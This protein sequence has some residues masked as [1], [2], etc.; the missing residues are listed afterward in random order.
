MILNG[1]CIQCLAALVVAC[2]YKVKVKVAAGEIFIYYIFPTK[3]HEGKL[4]GGFYG[5]KKIEVN[6][7]IGGMLI[8]SFSSLIPFGGIGWP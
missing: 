3:I 6:G 8:Y 1:L 7:E 4:V 2:V 5:G